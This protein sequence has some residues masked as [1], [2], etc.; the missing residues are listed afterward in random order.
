MSKH[1]N[2]WL[3]TAL[4]LTLAAPAFAEDVT[5][6][7]VVATVNGTDI[8]LGHMIATKTQ[9]PEQYQELPD[10]VLFQ[11]I[12]EQ[13]IQQ[14]VLSQQVTDAPRAAQYMIDNETRA[15]LA[16]VTVEGILESSLTEEAVQAAYEAEFSETD[17]STEYNAAHI[18]VETEE[19]A[20]ELVQMLNDGSDFADL[21]REK[22]TGPSG[23]NGGALG[24][25]GPGMMVAPFEE[26]VVALE[27]GQVSAPVETQFG[28]H[29]VMLNETR[30]KDAPA[31]EDV[32][33]ELEANLQ[34][35]AME[36]Q[37]AA[38]VEGADITQVADDE[39]DPAMLSNTA[40]I[41]E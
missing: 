19:E 10:E 21:A 41:E 30:L 35:A 4:A 33:A 17:P 5:A 16:S 13:L 32:R 12:K 39:I 11:G 36:A 31:L 2:F 26:A 18:L 28:W 29:V 40:L 37:L 25:F 22:S 23:A 15:I 6:D 27:P 9:L 8:T 20:L 1:T 3:G 14:V 38:L 24:W 34:R 7:T